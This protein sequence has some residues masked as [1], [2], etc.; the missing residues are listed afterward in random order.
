M[1]TAGPSCGFTPPERR[2]QPPGLL[3]DAVWVHIP[4]LSDVLC[5]SGDYG[6]RC[7]LQGF[8]GDT[9]AKRR[10][11]KLPFGL[12]LEETEAPT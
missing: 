7:T 2:L 11:L 5:S 12:G 3:A 10:R 8:A 9:L 1:P 4:T 6:G